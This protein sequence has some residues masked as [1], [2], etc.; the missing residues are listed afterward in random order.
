MR[1]DRE[2]CLIFATMVAYSECF[3][4]LSCNGSM[5]LFETQEHPP[6]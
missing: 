5:A 4:A 2:S 6:L 3:R 1:K